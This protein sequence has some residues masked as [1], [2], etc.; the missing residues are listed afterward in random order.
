MKG[1]V[2][3]MHGMFAEKSQKPNKAN[4]SS[5]CHHLEVNGTSLAFVARS[6][7]VNLA[8][9]NVRQIGWRHAP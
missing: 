4:V 5:P 1:G 9:T 8:L 3:Y 6:T 7:A 2:I